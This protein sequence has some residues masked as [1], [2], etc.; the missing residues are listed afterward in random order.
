MVVARA[1]VGAVEL[2]QVVVLRAALVEL[3][4]DHIRRH[5]GDHTGLVGGEHVTGVDGREALHAG[6]DQRRLGAQ[7]RHGLALHVRTH[8]GAVRVVVLE[9][10]DERG[11]DRHHL[12]RR[13]IHVP[14]LV[15]GDQVDLAALLA[16]EHAGLGEAGRRW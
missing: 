3:H 11:R 4:G 6:A 5:L 15:D 8:E 1:L 7:Q 2:A 14:D 16:G 12:A 9:E 10:R 13:D